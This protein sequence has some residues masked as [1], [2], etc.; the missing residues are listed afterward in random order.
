MAIT[1]TNAHLR[2]RAVELSRD[3]DNPGAI[4]IAIYENN[5]SVTKSSVLADFHIE[6]D[7]D[8]EFWKVGAPYLE[9]GWWVQDYLVDLTASAPSNE[10]MRIY[11]VLFYDRD[12]SST[13]RFGINAHPFASS[14][15]IPEGTSK[16]LTLDVRTKARQV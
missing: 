11:G 12:F 9:N 2:F 10:D 7:T 14:I 4:S 6:R 5:V 13:Q 1:L 3:N 8:L 16:I 15:L